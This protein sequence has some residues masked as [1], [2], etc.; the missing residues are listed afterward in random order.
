MKRVDAVE[1]LQMEGTGCVAVNLAA[2]AGLHC[3]GWPRAIISIV[4]SGRKTPHLEW[5][6][7]A[8]IVLVEMSNSA[9]C[10]GRELCHY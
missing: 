8:S 9:S 10:D 5:I 2:G 4:C 6:C 7:R 3:H 1:E